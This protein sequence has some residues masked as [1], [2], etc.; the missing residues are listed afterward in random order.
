MKVTKQNKS[1]SD[2]I[3]WLK[4][5]SPYSHIVILF[6][7]QYVGIIVTVKIQLY[8]YCITE[9]ISL[10]YTERCMWRI[11][12]LSFTYVRGWNIKNVYKYNE[13]HYNT[14]TNYDLCV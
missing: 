5:K 14:T 11:F 3:I 1:A 13:I 12:F 9:V 8:A 4:N 6:N 7:I 10:H 2:S